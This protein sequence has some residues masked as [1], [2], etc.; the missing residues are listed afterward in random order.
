MTYVV[1][2]HFSSHNV[3]RAFNF[4]LEQRNWLGFMTLTDA[5]DGLKYKQPGTPAYIIG[6]DTWYYWRN[7]IDGFVKWSDQGGGVSTDSILFSA[8]RNANVVKDQYLRTED[9]TPMNQAPLLTT[10]N[11][12]I[13]AISVTTD[14]NVTCTFEIHNNGIL[15]PGATISL[16]AEKQK[17]LPFNI[18]ITAGS[19][20]MI[21]NNGTSSKPKVNVLL[22]RI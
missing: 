10:L 13:A 19:Q 4:L 14:S 17:F 6:E 3:G 12:A 9:G 16:V 5:I 20:L 21:Y 18:P 2:I 11:Y 7:D 22:K 15:I 1:P 8:S